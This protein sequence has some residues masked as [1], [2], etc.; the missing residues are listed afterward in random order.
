MYTSIPFQ[1]Q[2]YL[3]MIWY[4]NAAGEVTSDAS[5][6]IDDGHSDTAGKLLCITH[7]QNL[8][9]KSNNQME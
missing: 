8:E 1:N 4:K 3:N 7:D 5:T 6:N 2:S 9:S